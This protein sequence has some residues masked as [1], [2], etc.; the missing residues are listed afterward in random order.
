MNNAVPEFPS[1]AVSFVAIR[2]WLRDLG[3]S[4]AQCVMW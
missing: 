1:V 2:E 3:S 4:L